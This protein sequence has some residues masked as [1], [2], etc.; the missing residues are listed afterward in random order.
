MVCL[1]K[2]TGS[3]L[4]SSSRE[5]KHLCGISRLEQPAVGC[6]GSVLQRTRRE[7]VCGGLGDFVGGDLLGFDLGKWVADVETYGSIAVYAPPEGGYEGRYATSLKAQGYKFM[8]MSAR[9]LGD[10]EAYLTKVH[11]VRPAHLGKQ[12]V[13]RWYCPPEV[14]YRLSVLP[15]NSKGLILWIIE[16][17]V[18]SKTELQFL[19][20]LPALRPNVKVI[21][22]CGSWRKFRWKP[23]KE[24]SGLPLNMET[25]VVSKAGPKVSQVK[26]EIE[27]EQEVE[28]EKVETE[29]KVE[30]EEKQAPVT[31]SS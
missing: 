8:N 4:I 18:L 17:Q 15:K 5:T 22:E 10:P 30:T 21:A 25:G 27:T 2:G 28:T 19:A 16:A 23:L 26:Q 1:S 13:A 29:Q 20:L 3:P 12:A 7:V 9:G 31:L 24:V 6:L 11:A 14:D